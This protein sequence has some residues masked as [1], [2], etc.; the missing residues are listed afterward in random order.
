MY[1]KHTESEQ[2]E[3]DTSFDGHVR[4]DV[5]GFAEPPVL[6]CVSLVRYTDRSAANM[7]NGVISQYLQADRNLSR[8]LDVRSVLSSSMVHASDGKRNVQNEEHLT[9][10]N[11]VGHVSVVQHSLPRQRP[12][13]RHP[14]RTLS[15]CTN[16]STSA[17]KQRSL[18]RPGRAYRQRTLQGRGLPVRWPS[19]CFC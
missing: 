13:S 8:R 5:E 7:H 16:D 19:C 17:M 14:I 4:K 15:V 3:S 6:S 1:S 10:V 12:R 9:S 2:H 18:S 11:V